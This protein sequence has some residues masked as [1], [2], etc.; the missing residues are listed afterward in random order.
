VRLNKKGNREPKKEGNTEIVNRNNNKTAKEDRQTRMG[1]KR[2]VRG[3]T[4]ETRESDTSNRPMQ[5]K[6]GGGGKIIQRY[7]RTEKK[8]MKSLTGSKKR[9]SK[10]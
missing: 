1:A 7:V 2:A 5:N 3:E 10:K 9:K 4:D 6:G 8:K